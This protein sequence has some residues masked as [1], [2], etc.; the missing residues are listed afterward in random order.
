MA[1]LLCPQATRTCCGLS[2]WWSSPPSEMLGFR[3]CEFPLT[4]LRR[5]TR[6]VFHVCKGSRKSHV[7]VRPA[8][9]S[10]SRQN[11]NPCSGC[12]AE[13]ASA[14]ISPAA[15]TLAGWPGMPEPQPFCSRSCGKILPVLPPRKL[16]RISH[17]PSFHVMKGRAPP[18]PHNS[19]F[20]RAPV[21]P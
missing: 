3:D 7:S 6:P 2:G 21:L 19:P 5:H 16:G 14:G 20:G 12:A 4:P 11:Q 18:F 13:Q 17:V 9:G 15:G 1:G 8:A 10:P